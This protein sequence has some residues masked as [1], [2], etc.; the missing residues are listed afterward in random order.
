MSDRIAFGRRGVDV[1]R[2]GPTRS[3]PVVA[4]AQDPVASPSV[5]RLGEGLSG[6]LGALPVMTFGIAALLIL[7]FSLEA[8]FAFDFGRGYKM[9]PESLLSF[10]AASRDLVFGSDEIW[11]VGLAPL[12]HASLEHLIGNCVA[13]VLIGVLLEPMIGGGWLAAIFALSGL[14]AVAA[15]LH[16]NPPAIP[17]VGASGAISGLIGAAFVMSFSAES[18]QLRGRMLRR[19]VFFGGPAVLPLFFGSSGSGT[20]YFAHA[21]GAIAG[22]ATALLLEQ[23]WDRNDIR[24]PHNALAAKAAMAALALSLLCLGAASRHYDEYQAIAVKFIPL[25]EFDSR[26]KTLVNHAPMLAMKYP[27]DP[28]SPVLLAAYDAEHGAAWEAEP[29][30]RRALSES[31]PLRPT[32]EPTRH[33]MA[34]AMLALVVRGQQRRAEAMDIAAPLCDGPASQFSSAMHEAKLCAGG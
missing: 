21:G 13:L 28:M 32:L 3:S 25:A 26:M 2:A 4:V 8:R 31:S 5:G 1:S 18:A 11:R 23:I 6:W 22:C 30:L 10:G 33:S 17:T 7:I 27:E 20:D 19:V 29:T 12:L 15:S 14:A 34:R 16:G 9:S 24:P